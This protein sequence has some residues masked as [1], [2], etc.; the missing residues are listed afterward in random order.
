MK[1][2]YARIIKG[3]AMVTVADSLVRLKF[4]ILIPVFSK[5]MG[6]IGYGVWTQVMVTV[7]MLLP[8]AMPGGDFGL[9]KF[10]PGLDK[11]TMSEK[12]SSI[13]W[14]VL[15]SSIMAG[16][17]I[18][19]FSWPISTIF[20]NDAKYATLVRLAGLYLVTFVLKEFFLKLFRCTSDIKR[21]SKYLFLE[22]VAYLTVG[23]VLA[24]YMR[25]VFYILAAYTAINFLFLILYWTIIQ[26]KIGLR[27]PILSDIKSYL[28]YSLPIIP[29][30][31]FLWIDNVA[32]RY[33]LG[34]F[35]GLSDVGIYAASYSLSYFVINF[36]TAPIL[37]L[38][39]PMIL[40]AWNKGESEKAKALFNKCIKYAIYL[41]LPFIFAFWVASPY[42][43]SVLTTRDFMSGI[44]AVPFVLCGY[45]FFAITAIVES[46]LLGRNKTK[47][48][49]TAYGASAIANIILNLALIPKMGI[50]GA[51]ISTTLTFFILMCL[52]ILSVVKHKI[53]SIDLGFISKVVAAS[54]IMFF[55]MR[56]VNPTSFIKVI[57]MTLCGAAIYFGIMFLWGTP[58][59]EDM[60]MIKNL[61]FKRT[62]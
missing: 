34:L 58:K 47:I 36:F 37:V 1:E 2:L 24:L 35:R 51:A 3:T 49:F 15:V 31:W 10:L 17:A 27:L 55:T 12:L 11:K 48:M 7:T 5:T 8:L 46:I 4:F 56:L 43:V 32:D 25:S 42:L 40:E 18:T 52:V 19:L 61:V 9:M 59:K 6:A 23:L 28:L 14:I 21:Y 60:A 26:K 41:I 54:L 44:F 50:K 45:L 30:A 62:T 13:L 39:Q 29:T 53:L 16:S 57:G 20:F 22:S 33:I 38:V